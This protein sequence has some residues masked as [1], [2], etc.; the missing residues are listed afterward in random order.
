MY[1][2]TL[3]PE[4]IFRSRRAQITRNIDFATLSIY[5]THVYDISPQPVHPLP[6]MK[7]GT[8]LVLTVLMHDSIPINPSFLVAL[9]SRAI[10]AALCDRCVSRHGGVDLSASS[11]VCR[12]KCACV[13]HCMVT[14]NYFF[15]IFDAFRF[16][17]FLDL[18]LR[19]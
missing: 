16:A 5:S 10:H 2:S 15:F 4:S 12:I 7:S 11:I 8:C 9:L 17:S 18:D 3:S 6:I 19:R 1:H 14:S 13:D